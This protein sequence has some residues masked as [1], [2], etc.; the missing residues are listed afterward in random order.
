MSINLVLADDLTGAC[1]IAGIA[2]RAGRLTHLSMDPERP[3][4]EPNS[5]LVVDTETRLL[6]PVHAAARMQYFAS[7]VPPDAAVFKKTDSVLRGPVAAETAALAQ[8]LNRPLT[9]LVPANPRLQRR[10]INGRYLIADTPL[11]LTPFRRDP[12]N[13]IYT[14]DVV[15]IL[16]DWEGPG[17]TEPLS[18]DPRDALP[19]AGLVIGN[20]ASI[21]DLDAWAK[22]IRPGTLPAGGG[23]FFTRLVPPRSNR[24]PSQAPS[25]EL[26]TLLISGTTIPA[27]RA[28]L[29]AAPDAV[30]ISLDELASRGGAALT[31]WQKRVR[32]HLRKRNRAL[33]YVEGPQSSDPATP[34]RITC[35]LAFL[36][37]SLASTF[38]SDPWHL[39]IEGGATAAAIAFAL[40]RRRFGVMHEWGLG[41]VTLAPSPGP[42]P[43][44]TLKPGSYPWP[45]ELQTRFFTPPL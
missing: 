12:L 21:E 5:L 36:V 44:F 7:A 11:H 39:I 9:L 42:Y 4:T 16:G 35:A 31:G 38:G 24:T 29:A 17:A 19:E 43:W 14:D 27:Q 30:P 45:V 34:G 25:L 20:A 2:H 26:P 10:I 37:E 3:P 33:V 13:P 8:H 18:L 6:L 32:R 15:A 41:V 1:E 28:L 23:A 40:G 22:R